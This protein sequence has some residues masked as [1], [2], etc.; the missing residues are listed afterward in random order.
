[1]AVLLDRDWGGKFN[2]TFSLDFCGPDD[3]AAVYRFQEHLK[4]QEHDFLRVVVGRGQHP[5]WER[6]LETP[7]TADMVASCLKLT[8]GDL[9]PDYVHETGTGKLVS[10]RLKVL[11][12]GIEAPGQ[13]YQL[14]PVDIVFP[15]GTKYGTQ[16]YVWNVYRKV[17]AIDP[18][19]GGVK[20]V[21]GEADGNHL[22]T[23]SGGAGMYSREKLAVKS[24][25]VAGMAAWRDWR[26]DNN[27]IFVCD[28]L[29][30]QMEASEMTGFK[31]YSEWS[32]I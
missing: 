32:E 4:Q 11:I 14:F 22:W 29:Y 27:Y 7:K 24:D 13:G 25:V 26:H 15:D 1:M 12:E 5:I 21:M 10:E 28:A 19:L 8:K 9:L 17:D 31:P 3:R 16:Y 23:Y 20:P 6:T 18:A 30:S 2:R